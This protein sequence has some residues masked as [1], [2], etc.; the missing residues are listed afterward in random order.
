MTLHEFDEDITLFYELQEFCQE[1]GC[2]YL[3]D[4][5]SDLDDAVNSDL[6]EWV[7]YGDYYWEDVYRALD[8]V[9][10]GYDFYRRDGSL[11]YM[12]CDDEDF[13]TLKNDVRDWAIE[14]E[15]FES[16]D[17]DGED[18]DEDEPPQS[19]RPR[20]ETGFEY[21]DGETVFVGVEEEENVDEDEFNKLIS[22]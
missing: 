8:N 14:N 2:D 5:F 18:N 1:H 20:L 4:Y 10:T 19:H 3:D 13:V 17:D 9:G 16:S 22:A 11:D 7:R 6:Y 15:I 21:I 12:G